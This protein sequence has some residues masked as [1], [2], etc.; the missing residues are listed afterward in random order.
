VGVPDVILTETTDPGRD[1]TSAGRAGAVGVGAGGGRAGAVGV[2][3]R[4]G[5]VTVEVVDARAR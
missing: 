5:E 2:P 3:G 4:V 1:N